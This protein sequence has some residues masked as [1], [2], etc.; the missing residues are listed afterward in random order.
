MK[1]IILILMIMLVVQITNP[2]MIY[3]EK[4]LVNDQA[5][6]L[7]ESEINSLENEAASLSQSYN[8]DI[9]IVTTNDA[10]GKSSREYADDFFDYY[11][12]GIGNNYD[13]ILFL[14]DMDNREVNI[15][16]SGIGIKYLTDER[17]ERVLDRVFENGMAGGD[18]YGASLGFLQGTK[19]Y[20][21]AGIPSD[22]HNVPEDIKKENKITLV[23]TMISIFGG[24]FT[25]GL[26]YTST[27][28]QYKMRKEAS[29]YSYRNN[30][31]I[32]FTPNNDRLIDTIVTQRLIPRP[33][34]R[35]PGGL[36]GG[37]STTHTSSSGRTH[38]G[39]GRKF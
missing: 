18:Y 23:D 35:P 26:F 2:Y 39:G 36:G 17:I 6:I 15:S 14:I 16:T 31:I 10:E 11:G 32:N 20:L 22:Q 25:G 7:S 29:Q 1:R 12:Y 28:A 37:R 3:A 38:G 13:G 9:V 19:S 4:Q 8:M 21:E 30:S 33:T 5:G 34:N 27:K 24:I